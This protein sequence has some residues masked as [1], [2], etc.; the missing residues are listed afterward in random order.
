MG[1][2][3]GDAVVSSSVGATSVGD[4]VVSSSVGA[5]SVG[6]GVVSSSVGATSCSV[7]TAVETS[8]AV[9]ISAASSF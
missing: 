9:G 5:T 7:I 3:I 1:S 6:D 8:S 4:G 2:S